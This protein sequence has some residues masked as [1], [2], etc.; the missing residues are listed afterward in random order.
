M[1]TFYIKPCSTLG[2]GD[3]AGRHEVFEAVFPSSVER[4]VMTQA[5]SLRLLCTGSGLATTSTAYPRGWLCSKPS[6]PT[7]F[8]LL[9][10]GHSGP[11]GRCT[12]QTQQGNLC[13]VTDIS[14]GPPWWLK[15]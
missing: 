13:R 8:A 4:Q 5:D 11:P 1:N 7:T 6:K 3:G 15:R 14:Q 12:S 2:G 10:A 9:T